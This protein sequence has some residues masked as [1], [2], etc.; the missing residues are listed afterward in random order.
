MISRF[1][2]YSYKNN[3]LANSGNIKHTRKSITFNYPCTSR[4]SCTPISL[5]VRP[6]VYKFECWGAKG[7]LWEFKGFAP[8]IPGLGAYTSGE[9]VIHKTTQFYVYIGSTGHFNCVR[10]DM[11]EISGITGGGATDVR[12]VSTNNWYDN[13]SLIS[14]IMVA[15][16]GAGS[17]WANVV[18]G[19]GGELVGG[20]GIY[21][22][23]ECKGASQTSGSSECSSFSYSDPYPGTF[24]VAGIPASSSDHGGIGGGG[25]YGG[26]SYNCAYS[27]SGGS[28]FISGHKGCIAVKD[29]SS[30]IIHSD[31]NIHYSNL[32]FFNTEMIGG[33]K[34]A[35]L[36]TGEK[37]IWNSTLGA[38]KI[39]IFSFIASC[40]VAR[41]RCNNLVSL[42]VFIICVK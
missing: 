14:R 20:S 29:S 12:L 17:E 3:A 30:P 6:G 13:E 16:G 31:Y 28:S 9:I 10:D 36:P 32:V 41:C 2:K 4:S 33:N 42:L 19:N 8:S 27:G 24:G 1:V 23:K 18:G 34:I 21:A 25:Y 7:G 38:F 15:A 40:K 11:Y 22:G 26:T 5:I 37:G 39:T 35:T